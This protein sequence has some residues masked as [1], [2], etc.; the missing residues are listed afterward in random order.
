M[1]S[2]SGVAALSFSSW[3]NEMVYCLKRDITDFTKDIIKED[4]KWKYGSKAAAPVAGPTPAAP[5]AV[6][7]PVEV[8]PVDPV[9][10]APVDTKEGKRPHGKG[11]GKGHHGKNHGKKNG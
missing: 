11:K 3:E 6:V 1:G 5:V 9:E 10:V 2:A 8:A 7:D 4:P